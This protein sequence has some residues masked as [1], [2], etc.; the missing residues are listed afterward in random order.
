M[1][2]QQ[3]GLP[4]WSQKKIAWHESIAQFENKKQ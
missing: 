1:E 3:D 2:F 4:F